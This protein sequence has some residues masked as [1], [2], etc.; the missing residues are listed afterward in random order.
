MQAPAAQ[1][2]SAAA[3][4]QPKPVAELAPKPMTEP[5]M[6]PT[7]PPPPPP[8]PAPAGRERS[9]LSAYAKDFRVAA[10]GTEKAPLPLER[11]RADGLALDD[12][13]VTVPEDGYYMVLWELGVAGANGEATL[14]LGINDAASQLTYALH[15]G[16]DSGQQ[17]TWLSKGD[18]VGLFARAEGGKAEVNCSSAQ[19]TVIRLG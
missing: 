16:Y 2:A 9:W 18:K 12:G 7:A 6:K 5:A 11:Q 8:P 4:S 17:V 10:E 19:F 14:Q 3:L 1:K 13:V 15:P